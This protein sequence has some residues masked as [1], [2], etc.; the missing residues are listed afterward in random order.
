MPALVVERA[1]S[2]WPTL[3][4]LLEGPELPG[5][6][7]SEILAGITDGLIAVHVTERPT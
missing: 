5:V 6:Q 7:K 1:S 3:A 4:H 2:S